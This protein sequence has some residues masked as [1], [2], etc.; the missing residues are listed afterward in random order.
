WAGGGYAVHGG[1]AQLEHAAGHGDALLRAV[2]GASG[3]AG[4]GR[5]VL[6][7]SDDVG[8]GP[9]SVDGPGSGE[10]QLDH[11]LA[12][13]DRYVAVGEGGVEPAVI[14]G[15]RRRQAGGGAC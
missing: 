6:D 2:G 7:H 15:P 12:R 9:E 4:G 14:R 13:G 11:P 10:D 3:A 8:G 1:V 5:E